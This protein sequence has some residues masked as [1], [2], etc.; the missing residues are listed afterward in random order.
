MEKF[1]KLKER[2]T[3]VR[4]EF[5]AGLTTFMAMAYILMV[6]ADMFA[7]FGDG[8]FNAVYIATAISAVIGTVLIG[9]LANLPLAQASG[10]GLNAF[11]VFTIC[12]KLGFTYANALV[13]V[14]FDGLL[15]ILLTLTGLRKMIFGAIPKAVRGA[16]S[17]GIGLFIAFLGMQSA[18]LVVDD[19]ATLVTMHSFNLFGESTTWAE[20]M[21]ILVTIFA[22]FI[23]AILSKRKVKGAVLWGIIGGALLYYVL[24]LVTITGFYDVSVAPNLTADVFGPFKDFANLG[25]GKLF[26]DGFNFKSYIAA[27]GMST[28]IITVATTALAFCMVDMFDTLGTLYGACSVGG[29]V[30]KEG[31]IPNM[32]RAMLA[33]AIATCTGAVCGTSTVTTFVESSAGVAEGGRTGLSAMFTALFFFIAMF[34]APVAAMIP[35][36]ATAAAL[37]YVGILMIGGVKDIEWSDPCTS[38]PAFLTMTMMPFTYNISYG[39]AFGMISYIIIHLFTGKIKEIKIGTWIIGALFT[40]MFFC[41]R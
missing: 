7:Y 11:F 15:F 25:F 24:G 4:I 37:I 17:A 34:L 31:N 23:I 14:L 8:Y 41:S 30:D 19:S 35:G 39:I 27:N 18:G 12:D 36:C 5:F 2:N 32:D 38:V 29:L 22:V 28:F 3:T 9:L 20:I 26:T 33:D 10:M 13:L 40:I 21:P 6:N 1:F 16:I